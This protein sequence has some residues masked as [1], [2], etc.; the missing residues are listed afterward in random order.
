MAEITLRIPEAGLVSP[1]TWLTRTKLS[2]VLQNIEA[3]YKPFI[4]FASSTSRIPKAVIT[5]FIAVESGG[6]PTAGASGHPTQGLMQWNREYA[7]K[8]LEDELAQGRMSPAEKNKL[9]EFGIK[10]DAKGKTRVIT[11]ADQLKPELN[12]LIG[13]IILGQLIDT[14]W[15]TDKNGLRLDRIIAVYNAGAFGDTGKKARLGSH[16]TASELAADVNVVTRAYIKKM[17]GKDGA[18]HVHKED[19]LQKIGDVFTGKA[20]A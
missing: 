20:K 4:S 1:D 19:L 13:S 16:K 9:A 6:N 5:S 3:K 10:F 2:E 14:N 8:Q 15:G 17:L 12:I 7:K 18:L 11:N